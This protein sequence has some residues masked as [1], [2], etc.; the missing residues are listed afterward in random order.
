M[1]NCTVSASFVAW[2]PT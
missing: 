2:A 1:T